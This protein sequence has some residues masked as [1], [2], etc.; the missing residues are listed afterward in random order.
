MKDF[1]ATLLVIL[2]IVAIFAAVVM[3][4]PPLWWCLRQL[5]PVLHWWSNYWGM[6]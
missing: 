6:L 3:A 5:A 2:I 4:I 1:T